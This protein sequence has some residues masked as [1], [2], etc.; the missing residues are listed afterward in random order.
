MYALAML[1]VGVIGASGYAGAELLRLCAGHPELEVVARHRRHARPARPVADL[2]PSLA[3][4]Y[5]DLVFRTYD[6]DGGRRSRPVLPG[7][8]PRR[9]AGPGGRAAHPGQVGRRPGRRLPAARRRAL[10]EWYGE[11]HAAPELLG[12]FVFG[13]PELFR[14]QIAGADGR[15]RARAATRPPPRSPLAPLVSAGLVEPTGIIVDAASGVSGAGRPP[16]PHDHVLH[17]RRGLHRL[18]PARPTGT[19]RRSSRPWPSRPGSCRTTC[20]CSSRR[21]SPR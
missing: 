3:A 4:A 21:T 8:A 11:A 19:R 16:K 18:R 17:G 13:L 5:P 12:E 9:V 14:D 10:P 2:Y 20:R 6:A 7:P 1:S 15:R